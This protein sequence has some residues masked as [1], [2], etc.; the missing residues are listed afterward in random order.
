MAKRSRSLC[1]EN[2]SKLLVGNK[3]DLVELKQ[4]QEEAAQKFAEKLGISFL[5]TS[6]KVST[7]QC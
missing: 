7:I 3:A 2:T 6:A 1:D 4:V 5:E